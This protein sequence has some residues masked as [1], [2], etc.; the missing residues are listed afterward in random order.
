MEGSHFLCPSA[1]LYAGSKLL[2][3]VN[4]NNEVDILREPLEVNA[5]FVEAANKGRVA[6]EK[7]RFVNKCVKSGCAQWTGTACS[8][9]QR[10]LDTMEGALL[11]D[12]LPACN[13]RPTCRWFAQ[14]G[15]KACQVCPMVKYLQV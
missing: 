11:K 10:V 4:E 14:E 15:S 6:E 5:A 12:E 13:I 7:F 9:I 2:G 8:V 1:P 3:V